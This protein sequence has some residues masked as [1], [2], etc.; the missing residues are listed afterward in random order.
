M[1]LNVTNEYTYTLETIVQAGRTKM[2]MTSVP[3]RTNAELRPSRLFSS[4]FGYVKRSMLTII[5]AFLMYKP[6][7]FFMGLGT[8]AEL[9]WE[10][11][12]SSMQL[13]E[14]VPVISSH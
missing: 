10:S 14:A 5:R 6:L 2:A 13:E 7:S 3:I 4:M 11:V 8:L 1:R 9:R 12:L